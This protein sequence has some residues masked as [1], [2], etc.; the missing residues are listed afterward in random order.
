VDNSKA[1][2][3]ALAHAGLN[4][5]QVTWIQVEKDE[6][7]GRIQYEIEFKAGGMEYEYTID[8]STGSILEHEK[9]L[10]D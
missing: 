10:D 5:S 6:D 7:D 2:S 8:A 9:D 4:E 1:K 3:I